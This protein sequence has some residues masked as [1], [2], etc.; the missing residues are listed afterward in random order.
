MADVMKSVTMHSVSSTE[1]IAKRISNPAIR[2][3]MPTAKNIMP[4]DTVIMAATTL[5]VT[6]TA[7][8]AKKNLHD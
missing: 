8:T 1:G 3:M 6:G 4:T 5:N 7:L 2:S